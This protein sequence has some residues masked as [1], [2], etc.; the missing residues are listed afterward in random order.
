MDEND[1][2]SLSDLFDDPKNLRT[3]DI[4]ELIEYLEKNGDIKTADGKSTLSI[5]WEELRR[6]EQETK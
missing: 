2:N 3:E 5:V 6:R 1:L 4:K